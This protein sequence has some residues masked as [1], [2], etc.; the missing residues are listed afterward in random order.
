MLSEKEIHTIQTSVIGK[1][2]ELRRYH[3]A[4]MGYKRDLASSLQEWDATPDSEGTVNAK[5]PFP[6]RREIDINSAYTTR[7]NIMK[8]SRN[9][10]SALQEVIREEKVQFNQICTILG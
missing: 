5:T 8:K 10:D 3:L 9:V 7:E 6:I 1:V 2:K 4:W